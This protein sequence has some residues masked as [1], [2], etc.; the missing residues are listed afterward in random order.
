MTTWSWR[1]SCP[2]AG[3]GSSRASC[4]CC[5]TGVLTLP[6]VR[7]CPSPK[8]RR[9]PC[10][11]TADSWSGARAEGSCLCPGPCLYRLEADGALDSGFGPR[12][13]SERC[14]V[15]AITHLL[16]EGG[17]IVVGGGF[18]RVNGVPADGLAILELDGSTHAAS[19]GRFAR[20]GRVASVAVDKHGAI[21][22]SG[23][24]FD[25]VAGRTRN[26]Y[27]RLHPSGTLDETFL[28][29]DAGLLQK[30]AGGLVPTPMEASW[31]S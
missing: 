16:A 11:R 4:G 27:A 8:S 23:S 26:G 12:F 6:S 13:E 17:W 10:R 28:V 31:W 20:I 30:T 14:Y 15:E 3:A 25:R 1:R 18:H 2:I 24:G 21:L 7:D 9:S 19:E 29:Q 22:A 5:R